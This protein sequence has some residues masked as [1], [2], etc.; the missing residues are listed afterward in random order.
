MKH[1]MDTGYFKFIQDRNKGRVKITYYDEEEIQGTVSTSKKGKSYLVTCSEGFWRCECFNWNEWWKSTPRVG[2]YCCKH[3]E[4]LH[5]EIA[6]LKGVFEQSKLIGTPAVVQDVSDDHIELSFEGITDYH[7]G[8]HIKINK[9]EYR[10]HQIIWSKELQ[11]TVMNL[12]K[13][14]R[15]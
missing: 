9:E 5:Y 3:I 1:K 13:V 6:R 12:Q 4:E 7:T 15:L 10:V 2:S 11:K 8:Q 14:T